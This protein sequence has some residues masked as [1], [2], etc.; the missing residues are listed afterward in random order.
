MGDLL[1]R[2]W[3]ERAW[4]YQESVLAREILVKTGSFEIAGSTIVSMAE[5][6]SQYGMSYIGLKNMCAVDRAYSMFLPLKKR[7]A[8][9]FNFWQDL[10]WAL[11]AR[12][13]AKAS[14][15][16]D[17]IYSLLGVAA[18]GKIS[19]FIPDYDRSWQQIYT[20]VA[21][22]IIGETHNLDILG[23]L[24]A[25]TPACVGASK[26]L[27]SWV[28]D[29]RVPL[30]DAHRFSSDLNI[31]AGPKWRMFFSTGTSA[32]SL[33]EDEVGFSSKLKLHGIYAGVV[34]SV[35]PSE[36]GLDWRDFHQFLTQKVYWPTQ[37][38]MPLAR[39][40]MLSLDASHWD[41]SN[42]DYVPKGAIYCVGDYGKYLSGDRKEADVAIMREL[43]RMRR[44]VIFTSL[45]FFGVAPQ[46]TK[47][48]DQLY[49]LPGA[50]FPVLLRRYPKEEI[51]YELT[52]ECYIHGLMNGRGMEMAHKRD[53]PLYDLTGED[54]SWLSRLHEEEMFFQKEEIVIC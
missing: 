10:F 37:E 17:I 3:F 51:E 5:C 6:R 7:P 19:A 46:S 9:G 26:A 1:Q 48:G 20:F 36:G 22:R 44:K 18:G 39:I 4:V 2:A 32:V 34:E 43:T 40:K 29:W 13:G 24:A 8:F 50:E 53:D 25:F 30:A 35:Q 41:P 27:S 54:D 14:D 52:G 28:P 42:P 49:L 38:P 16:R 31:K 33:V 47:V 45:G 21:K 12:R 15:P 11:R 23:E